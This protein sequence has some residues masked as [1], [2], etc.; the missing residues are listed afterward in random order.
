[1]DRG[2]VRTSL[3]LALSG[4]LALGSAGCGGYD[5]GAAE[6]PAQQEQPQEKGGTGGGDDG[7]Y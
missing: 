7:G 2:I 1:M 4:A 5:G 6:E 3:A